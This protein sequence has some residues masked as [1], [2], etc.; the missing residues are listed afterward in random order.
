MRAPFHESGAARLKVELDS[1]NGRT[2]TID[3]VLDTGASLCHIPQ[4]VASE[5]GL[6]QK[7]WFSV[8][9]T[10]RESKEPGY[11]VRLVIPG[12]FEDTVAMKPDYDFVLVGR[13]V[14][15]ALKFVF[16]GPR[17]EFELGRE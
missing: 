12:M 13:G 15:K 6:A 17:R 11:Y 5:M 4:V 14:L 16:D 3:G 8:G 1:G 2:R 9:S 10:Q 7:G